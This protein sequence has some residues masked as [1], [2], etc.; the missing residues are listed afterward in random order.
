MPTFVRLTEYKN[1]EEKEKVFFD[2][3]NR[4]EAKQEDFFKIPEA[5]I[6]YWVSD[7]VKEIFNSSKK[8]SN[9]V[10]PRRGFDTNDN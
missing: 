4:Y 9:F 5:P 6:A 1:G 7:R 10:N 8:I 2:P 3:K